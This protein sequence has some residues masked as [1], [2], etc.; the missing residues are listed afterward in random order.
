MSEDWK[1]EHFIRGRKLPSAERRG[2]DNSIKATLAHAKRRAA[3]IP[4]PA[5]EQHDKL[6]AAVM[7]ELQ[8]G[9]WKDPQ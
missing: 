6:L 4:L 5:K 3:G 7:I 9:Q 8:S 1:G 2:E